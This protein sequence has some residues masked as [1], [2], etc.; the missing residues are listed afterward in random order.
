MNKTIY[1]VVIGILIV[2]GGYFILQREDKALQELDAQPSTT[3]ST[4]QNQEQIIS[5]RNHKII[6]PTLTI[7]AGDTVTWKNEDNLKGFPY[8]NH[9]PTSGTIDSMGIQGKKGVVPNSGSGIADGIFEL[10]LGS[11]ESQ[12]FTFIQVGTYTYYIAEHPLV[13]GEGKIIVEENNVPVSMRAGNFFFST[14]TL[15][16]RTGE[17]VVLD[18]DAIGQ[19]TFSI[20]ELG[21][22]VSLS[23]GKTTR[24]EF[25][26]SQEGTFTYYCAIPGHLEGGMLGVLTVK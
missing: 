20:D 22:N 10:S 12:S 2:V 24:V 14:K 18:I 8:D 23:N 13:S 25:T 9:S 6:K 16:T 3:Q 4:S 21:V 19:H 1:I 17:N 5:I 11:G 26:P 7:S 15:N